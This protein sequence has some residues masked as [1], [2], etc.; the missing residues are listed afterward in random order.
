MNPLTGDLA[1]YT[2][3][4]CETDEFGDGCELAWITA[5]GM[6]E[7]AKQQAHEVFLKGAGIFRDSKEM[8]SCIDENRF[9]TPQHNVCAH[10]TCS[11]FTLNGTDTCEIG[12]YVYIY[13][14]NGD[15]PIVRLFDIKDKTVRVWAREMYDAAC[16][17][18]SMLGKL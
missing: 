16:Q 18:A 8:F 3:E 11:P 1:G 15:M 10:V 4:Y 14:G 9:Q 2:I 13:P 6:F 12:A 7:S 17:K 5:E